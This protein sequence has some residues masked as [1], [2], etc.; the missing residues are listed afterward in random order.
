MRDLAL[1]VPVDCVA[2]ISTEENS[3]ALAYMQ[4]VTKADI[5]PSTELDLVELRRRAGDCPA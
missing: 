5:R 1:Y 3:R 4:R 2:S